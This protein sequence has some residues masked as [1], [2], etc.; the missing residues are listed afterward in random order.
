M[1]KFPKLRNWYIVIQIIKKQQEKLIWK[2]FTSLMKSIY[3]PPKCSTHR[4]Q[5]SAVSKKKNK[6]VGIQK[7]NQFSILY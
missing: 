5:L 6:N 4:K 2:K 7:K 3:R 1:K